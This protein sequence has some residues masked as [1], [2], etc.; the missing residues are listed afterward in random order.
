[1]TM[2]QAK[3]SIDPPFKLSP[4]EKETWDWAL[5]GMLDMMESETEEDGNDWS[6]AGQRADMLYR[7]GTQAPDIARVEGEKSELRRLDSFYQ[8]LV[9]AWQV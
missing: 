1:M 6:E 2:A 7:I 4:W 3:P 5:A 8:K 9:K